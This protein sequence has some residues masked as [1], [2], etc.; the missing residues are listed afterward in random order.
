MDK[1]DREESEMESK[2]NQGFA[3]VKTIQRVVSV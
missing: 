1:S 2:K 3:K